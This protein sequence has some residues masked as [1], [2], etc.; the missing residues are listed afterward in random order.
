MITTLLLTLAL[1][2]GSSGA[3]EIA[4]RLDVEQS[5][6]RPV[7]LDST[8]VDRSGASCDFSSGGGRLTIS[9]RHLSE[10]LNLPAEVANL[11][12]AVPGSRVRE[13]VLPG[14]RAFLLDLGE[15]GAQLHIV[16]GTRDYLM[17]SVLG[18]GCSDSVAGVAEALAKK[19]LSRL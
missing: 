18:M 12:A 5:L 14:A 16:R 13:I 7:F 4:A 8:G 9:V 15:A 11:K 2:A 6:G 10:D 19:A 17:I 1:S 3:C